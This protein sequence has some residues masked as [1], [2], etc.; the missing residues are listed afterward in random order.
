MEWQ[1]STAALILEFLA[2]P[3]VIN[4]DARDALDGGDVIYVQ[5]AQ[6]FQSCTSEPGEEGE[7]VSPLMIACFLA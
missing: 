7:P 4:T 6:L 1:D 2:I 3:A 5:L